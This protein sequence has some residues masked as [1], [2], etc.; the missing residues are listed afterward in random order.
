MKWGRPVGA[1]RPRVGGGRRLIVGRP[2][3]AQT[4]FRVTVLVSPFTSTP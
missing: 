4:F 3:L 1:D 2:G